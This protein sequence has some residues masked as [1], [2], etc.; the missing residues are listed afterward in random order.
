[1]T[2]GARTH[3]IEIGK[4]AKCG[5]ASAN[6]HAVEDDMLTACR[7]GRP[8][9]IVA[10]LPI[11]SVAYEPEPNAKGERLIWVEEISCSKLNAP[12]RATA[13]S[14]CDSSSR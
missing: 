5:G 6:G 4:S 10:T 11:G 1:M 3:G 7:N 14:S 2:S 8:A 9:P 12:A 13:T